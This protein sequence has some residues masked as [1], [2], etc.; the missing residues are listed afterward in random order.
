MAHIAKTEGVRG[1]FR[2]L[3]PSLCGIIPY[4]GIDFAIFDY[5]KRI[6]KRERFGECCGEVSRK[7]VRVSPHADFGS[8]S[9][10]GKKAEF[11]RANLSRTS[12]WSWAGLNSDGDLRPVTKI[13]CGAA[14]LPESL[15]QSAVELES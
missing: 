11:S 2:G 6:C 5:A 13:T 1:L 3:I 10:V 14:I 8:S 15:P 9:F 7:R 4:I 12:F